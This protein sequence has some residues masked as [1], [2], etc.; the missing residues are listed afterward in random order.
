MRNV[1]VAV[2]LTIGAGCGNA[3]TVSYSSMG[4][5]AGEMSLAPIPTVVDPEEALLEGIFFAQTPDD[6]EVRLPEAPK[7]PISNKW[8][9][10]LKLSG[11]MAPKGN[12]QTKSLAVG[13]SS[14]SGG[15]VEVGQAG[16]LGDLNNDPTAIR[17]VLRRNAGQVSYCHNVA[18]SRYSDVAGRVELRWSIQEGKVEN[19]QVVS[20]STGDDRMAVCVLSKVMRMEFPDD[21][22]VAS[23]DHP[24]VFQK[25]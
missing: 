4:G 14:I 24:F 22:S 13:S 10:P 15:S 18:K 23:V 19:A 9:A 1:I 16:P 5:G 8:D 25:G 7:T 6:I 3:D 17:E 20:N 11:G 12:V 2:A 21:M